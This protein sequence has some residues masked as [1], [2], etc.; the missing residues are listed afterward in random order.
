MMARQ[1]ILVVLSGPSGTGKGTICKELLQNYPNLHYSVSATTRSPRPGEI[2]GVNYWFVSE[3]DFKSMAAND[4]LLEWAEVY[5]RFYGTPI[6]YVKEQLQSGLDVIL[7]IDIQG[8]M[9]VKD[10]FPQGV[11]VFI[12][13]PSI[14]ELETRIHK[15]GTETQ[16][17]IDLRLSCVYQE[18]S[19]IYN[20]QYVVVN[21]EVPEAV[22]K[23]AA[24]VE[25][26]KCLV[27]RNKEIVHEIAGRQISPKEADL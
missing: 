25:A 3:A 22:R 14:N 7:E 21:D 4:E 11:F 18:L 24:I 17:L 6:K 13:P 16:D 27:A 5:G 12:V 23:I 2:N 19:F 1:G 10:K 15:R 20:Y 26:E 8:A 9:Q